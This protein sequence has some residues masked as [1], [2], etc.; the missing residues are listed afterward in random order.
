VQF[1]QMLP[2][3]DAQKVLGMAQQQGLLEMPHMQQQ[4]P[5]GRIQTQ[6]GGGSIVEKAAA[7]AREGTAPV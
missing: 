4:M 7:T 2:P 1:A 5:M 3:E 6:E